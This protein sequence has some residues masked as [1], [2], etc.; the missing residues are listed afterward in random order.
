MIEMNDKKK[1]ACLDADVIIKMSHND[2]DLLEY[3]VGFFDECYLHK[4]VYHEVEWPEETVNLLK[5]WD[6]LFY[7]FL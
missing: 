5:L 1:I 4:Q 3:V 6:F 7:C 2:S